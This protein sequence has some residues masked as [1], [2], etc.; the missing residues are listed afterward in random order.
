M[1]YFQ[2]KLIEPAEGI[3]V[4]DSLENLAPDGIHIT[5]HALIVYL[6]AS[7]NIEILSRLV[8]GEK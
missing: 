7:G 1:I 2:A 4:K 3:K 8:A 5:R 6:K